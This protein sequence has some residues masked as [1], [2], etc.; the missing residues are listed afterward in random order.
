MKRLNDL[1]ARQVDAK[2]RDFVPMNTHSVPRKGWIRTIRQALGM[3][4]RQ[5]SERT[6]LSK[7]TV[8]RAETAEENG[9]IQLNSL[10]Q[11]ANGL[12]CDLVYVLKPRKPLQELV[13][14]QAER[15]A[16]NIVQRV[17]DSM[18]LEDQ[19]VRENEVRRQIEE[20]KLELLRE[21]RRELWNV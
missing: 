3:S 4:L 5:L 2:L 17:S 9:V 16:T 14:S 8:A 13:E 21:H 20:L 15:L 19:K 1:R 6:G 11:I 12:D 7:T 18:K 10:R